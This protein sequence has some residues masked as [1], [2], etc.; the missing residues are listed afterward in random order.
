MKNI[1]KKYMWK[2]RKTN[3]EFSDIIG[4]EISYR[5]T[6]PMGLEISKMK[7]NEISC[8]KCGRK[9]LDYRIETHT[10]KS[11]FDIPLYRVVCTDEDCNWKCPVALSDIGEA[12]AEFKTWLEAYMLMGKPLDLINENLILEFYPE[13]KFRDEAR[14]EY[15]DI[16]GYLSDIEEMYDSDYDK[17]LP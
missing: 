17:E 6:S 8:P 11:G 10:T 5:N 1:P 16:E 13:G 15:E 4:E 9:Y 3:K 14:A 2:T 7:I 12:F